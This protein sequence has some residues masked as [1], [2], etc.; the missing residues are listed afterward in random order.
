MNLRILFTSDVHAYIFPTDYLSKEEKDMGL[1][2]ISSLFKKYK[3]EDPDTLLID[4]GDYIQGSILAQYLFEQKK[5]PSFLMNIKDE[6]NYDLSVIGN[7]EYNFGL[8]YLNK[9]IK[10]SHTPLMSANILDSKKENAY[11][12][13]TIIERKGIKVGIIALTTQYIKNWELD[14]NIRGLEFLSAK[15]VCQKYVSLLRDKV[16]LL[17]V[18]YHGGFERDLYTAEL[19][20]TNQGENEG[21][22]IL[23]NIKGIDL[24]LTGHQHRQI[25]DIIDGVGVIQPGK[26]GEFVGRVDIEFDEQKNIVNKNLALLDLKNVEVDQELYHKYSYIN[27]GLDVWMNEEI[28][29]T[30]GDMKIKDGFEAMAFGCSY[31]NFVNKVQLEKTGAQISSTSL[32]LLDPPGFED[33]ITRKNVLNNYPYA[34]TLTVLRITGKDLRKALARNSLYF[35]LDKD[36]NIIV[37]PSYIKPKP[38]HYNYDLY[39]GIE[40]TIDLKQEEENRVLSLSYK[41]RQ[42]K[43]T[44]TF[45][46]VTNQY[47]ALGGGDFPMFS[48]DKIIRSYEIAVNQLLV[49]EIKK[50]R[51]IKKESI[52]NFTMIK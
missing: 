26:F 2:K 5:D 36:K 17:V 43:D 48:K 40:F 9:A 24:L 42:V 33:V 30:D 39:Y 13:Y 45:E 47:R 4:L 3:K 16:D 10:A 18:A 7:H 49:E 25:V 41:G 38:K 20:D 8:A 28:G 44:D 27:E 51:L 6:L 11:K 37:D 32:F 34:N 46:L 1:L 35:T 12:P 23:K 31:A 21:Y 52:N 22:E 15:D 14:E 19:V 29:R 50:K